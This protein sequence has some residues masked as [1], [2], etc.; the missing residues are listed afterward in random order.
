MRVGGC[1]ILK[2]LLGYGAMKNFYIFLLIIVGVVL[3]G[4]GGFVGEVVYAESDV[5]EEIVDDGADEIVDENV[6]NENIP[7]I[8]IKAI[9]PG[10]TVDGKSNVGEMI[11]IGFRKDN[12]DD[13]ISLASISLSYTNSSGN[14]SELISFSE[15]L[16]TASESIVLRLAS[17]VDAELAN[18]NY[19]KTL[20]FQGG[21]TLKWGDEMLDAV[22][23]T[24]KEGCYKAFK[25]SNPT[26]LVRNLATNEFEHL[27]EYEPVYQADVV[28]DDGA[29]GGNGGAGDEAANNVVDAQCT[30]L[31]FSEVLSYYAETQDEQFVELYNSGSEQVLLDGCTLRYKNKYYKLSGILKAEEYYVRSATEFSLTKNPI[32]SN[33]LEI[34]DVN[35]A[36][37][38]KLEYPNGQRKGAS[39]AFVGYGADGE[40][41]WR[42]TYAVTRGEANNYQEFKTC[43]EGKVIN[44]ATGNCVKVATVAAEKTCEA[45]YYLNPLTGRCRKIEVAVAK[46]CK[47]GYYLNEETGRC[48]KI[49]ENNGA[50]YAL[51]PEEYKE[52]TSFV[53]VYA[54]IGV[55]AAGVIYIIFEFRH[56]IA[57]LG[58]KVFRRVR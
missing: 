12:P 47:E 58:R 42:V 36:V 24:G 27:S 34:I 14:E 49:I 53:A 45:G 15:H 9:N 31:M 7:E 17:S 2:Y 30:G 11:E 38:D 23:W 44:E 55:L 21:L 4:F 33:L 16:K 25:S 48:R 54:I 10:Y 6:V 19:T 18:F 28:I 22:C 52:E 32:N 56:E 46:T 41:I 13:L 43:E 20:A 26:V 8:F 37:V 29:G 51:E 1:I 40:E 5:G 3:G 50:T 39:Y 57:K 35:G